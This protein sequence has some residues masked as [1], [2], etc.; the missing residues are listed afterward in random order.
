MDKTLIAFRDVWKT[1]QMGEIQ[2]NALKEVNAEFRKG[3][4]TAI[5]GP[6][7]SGKS[8]MMNLVGCLDVPSEG[9]IFLKSKN[10]ASLEES[11]LAALRGKTIGFIFQ[12]Y[13]LIPGMTALENVLLPLEI[14]EIDDDIAEK[15]AKE[16]LTLVGLSDKMKNRPS[17]LSGG[18]QQRVSIARALAS[19]PDIILADEPTGA[20]DSVTGKEVMTMLYRLWKENGKTVIMVTHDMHLAQ[21]AQRHIELKDGEVVRDEPNQ[22]QFCPEY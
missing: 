3:E 2:V 10:I 9:E 18:Q 8:T 15:R 11:D 21:Y 6:S 4:F 12:Q 1:Y 17:Q 7:G 22:D 14:Q 16:L 19:N 20:L 13:N 5:I